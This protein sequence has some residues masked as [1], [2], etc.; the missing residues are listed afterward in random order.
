MEATIIINNLK[1]IFMVDKSIINIADQDLCL[2]YLMM[3]ICLITSMVGS[4]HNHG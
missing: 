4:D 2:I 1:M 3:Q